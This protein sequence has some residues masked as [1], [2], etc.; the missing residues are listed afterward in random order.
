MNCYDSTY[1]GLDTMIN[2]HGYYTQM[3]VSD[4]H[5]K[6]K[7]VNGELVEIGIDTTYLNVMFYEDGIFI[8]NLGFQDY[9]ASEGLEKMKRE[10]RTFNSR[11]EYHGTY[12][13]S[14]DTVKTQ[15]I[16]QGFGN[17]WFAMEVWYRIIDKSTL[18]LF[19]SKHLALEGPDRKNPDFQPKFIK[20]APYAKF[21]YVEEIPESDSWLKKEDWFWCK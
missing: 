4:K 7:Y 18:Q 3:N 1:T 20:D 10:G 14:G 13:V 11:S 8:R 6:F 15:F 21:V 16:S 5:G 2:I 17:V 12:K 9:A 19:F